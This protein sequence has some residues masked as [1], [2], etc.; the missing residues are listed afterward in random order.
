MFV[1][2]GFCAHSVQCGITG[3]VMKEVQGVY[4]GSRLVLKE[5]VLMF[6]PKSHLMDVVDCRNHE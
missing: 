4:D 6:I 1:C 2:A 5:H 3:G